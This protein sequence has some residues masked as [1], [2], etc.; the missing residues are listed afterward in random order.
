[1]QRTKAQIK[2]LNSD[3]EDL[4]FGG[5]RRTRTK[6]KMVLGNKQ[7]WGANGINFFLRH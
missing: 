7:S 1:M 4:L 2:E 3:E 5:L 6:V